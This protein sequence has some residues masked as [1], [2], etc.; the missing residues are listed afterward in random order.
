M[1]EKSSVHRSSTDFIIF[2]VILNTV[3]LPRLKA[4]LELTQLQH[5]VMSNYF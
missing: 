5:D 2:F 4:D 1:V 3:D